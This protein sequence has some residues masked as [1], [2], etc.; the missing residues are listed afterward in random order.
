[1]KNSLRRWQIAGFIFTAVFGAVLHFLYDWTN[2]NG[3]AALFSA[4]NESIWEHNKLIFFPMF[5]FSLIE[6]RYIGKEYKSFWCVKLVGMVLGIII[7]PVLY[8]TIN[9]I[10]GTT[11]D[12]V[13]IAIF[14]VSVAIC[15]IL[16][17]FH[18]ENEHI[19]CKL[20]EKAFLVL[21]LIAVVFAVFTYAPPQ[22]PLFQD[23]ITNTFGV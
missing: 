3:V 8:Y 10:F 23:P 9:G 5:I 22:I 15:Y 13:N 12:W 11:P 17:T 14:F 7:V 1:M 2:Q 20:P 18:L 6:N 21:C 16:E 4:V 19:N